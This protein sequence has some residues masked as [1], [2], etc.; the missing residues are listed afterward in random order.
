MPAQAGFALASLGGR[1]C[2]FAATEEGKTIVAPI[3]EHGEGRGAT[4]CIVVSPPV[5][6]SEEE[7]MQIIREELAK[8][9]I[10]LKP[11]VALKNVRIPRRMT[12]ATKDGKTRLKEFDFESDP[13]LKALSKEA[14]E[15]AKSLAPRPLA[16]NGLDSNKKVAVEFISEKNYS[17]LGGPLSGSTVQHYDFKEVARYVAAKAKKQGKEMLYLGI[18]YEP[19]GTTK[20]ELMDSW[21]KREEKGKTEAG[22][23]LRSQVQD[24]TAWLKEKKVIQKYTPRRAALEESMHLTLHLTRACNL[25]CSYCYSP[26]AAGPAMTPTIGRHAL[27][28]GSRLCEGSCGIVFFGGEPLLHKDLMRELL[29]EGRQME[30]R[31]QGR[32]HFKL[33]TNGLLLDDEFLDFA[34]EEDVL[35]AMSLD[36][37]REAHDRHRRLAD[38]SPSFDRLL[39]RLRSLLAARPYAS[40][41]MVVNP[42]TAPLLT[43]SVS[44]LFDEGCRY[45]IVSLNYAGSW[46][47]DDL[48]E[49]RRQ[50][51]RLGD[52]YVQWTRQGRKFYLSP[53]EMKLSSHVQGEEVCKE[54]CEL[55]RRQISV[56]PQGFLFPCVQFVG[57]GPASRWCIG[58]VVSGIN[59]AARAR[60]R[61]ESQEQKA[62]CRDCAIRGRCHNTCGC[63]N[64]QTTGSVAEVSPVLCRHEQMLVPIAD[65]VGDTL[66]REQNLLFLHKHYNPAYPVLSILEDQGRRDRKDSPLPM[67]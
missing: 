46:T 11:G 50:Y 36:G 51:E 5:F 56:D 66:Y 14:R 20:R 4:G 57:A 29:A 8:H 55:G 21:K 48:D 54:H 37:V 35:I 10:Q 27:E 30:K 34:L 40:V 62:P 13:E 15:A 63:L 19:A 47:E 28:L 23:L 64:W 2:V 43:E 17:D 6:L 67:P 9:G 18:F 53:F 33:T 58:D 60:L 22:K 42:D 65:G 49:L 39:P 52:L 25:R 26:P 59:D 61:D 41:L 24:F 3:F 12:L 7:A 38:G 31:G 44:F 16:L 45:L 1:L 32:F